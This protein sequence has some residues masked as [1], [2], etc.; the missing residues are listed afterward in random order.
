VVRDLSGVL[1]AGAGKAGDAMKFGLLFFTVM[2]APGLICYAL[3]FARWL[4]DRGK[5]ELITTPP[6][7]ECIAGES[8]R[9]YTPQS[10]RFTGDMCHDE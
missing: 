3:D 1:P 7:S 5:P 4:R 10:D 6:K 2:G 9:A 8:W